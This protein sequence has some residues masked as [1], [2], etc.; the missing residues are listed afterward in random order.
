MIRLLLVEDHKSVRQA[1]REGLEATGDVRVVAEAATAREAISV[2]E[3]SPADATGPEV[4]LMDVELRD[5]ELG[6]AARS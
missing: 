4:A 2:L 6:A 3:A 5:P 1:L